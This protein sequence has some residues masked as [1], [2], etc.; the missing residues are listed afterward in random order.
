MERKL[1]NRVLDL[2]DDLKDNRTLEVMREKIYR[3]DVPNLY[4]IFSDEE[5]IEKA[6]EEY[7][8]ILVE[9]NKMLDLLEI[10]DE[11]S[12]EFYAKMNKAFSALNKADLNARKKMEEALDKKL[13]NTGKVYLNPFE[14]LKDE[15][16]I[17]DAL[18]AIEELLEATIAYRAASSEEIQRLAEVKT[19]ILK[20]ACNALEDIK[21]HLKEKIKEEEEEER[22]E[23]SNQEGFKILSPSEVQDKK[24]TPGITSGTVEREDIPVEKILFENEYIEVEY[25]QDTHDLTVFPLDTL[26]IPLIHIEGKNMAVSPCTIEYIPFVHSFR[27]YSERPSIFGRDILNVFRCGYDQMAG[28]VEIVNHISNMYDYAISLKNKNSD[29]DIL[30]E[31]KKKINRVL[32]NLRLFNVYNTDEEKNPKLPRIDGFDPYCVEL[33]KDI[34]KLDI[35][36]RIEDRGNYRLVYGKPSIITPDTY[37][38]HL[39]KYS[40]INIDTS[41]KYCRDYP[42]KENTY[43]ATDTID[44][45]SVGENDFM[46]YKRTCGNEVSISKE[47]PL[48]IYREVYG[49][50]GCSNRDLMIYT[51]LESLICDSDYYT[52][53]SLHKI[54]KQVFEIDGLTI[55]KKKKEAGNAIMFFKNECEPFLEIEKIRLEMSDGR[56][57][58]IYKGKCKNEDDPNK[59]YFYFYVNNSDE[60]CDAL[61][62]CYEGSTKQDS[63]GKQIMIRVISEYIYEV[64]YDE[65]AF[66]RSYSLT[67]TLNGLPET[68]EEYYDGEEGSFDDDVDSFEYAKEC[69]VLEE[70]KRFNGYKSVRRFEHIILLRY[71]LSAELKND[72]KVINVYVYPIENSRCFEISDSA[73]NDN[74]LNPIYFQATISKGEDGIV[75]SPLYQSFNARY[76]YYSRGLYEGDY[77]IRNKMLEELCEPFK[78]GVLHELVK[79]Y[80]DIIDNK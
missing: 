23:K 61:R 4:I 15:D 6:N 21:E 17:E 2:N 26:S 33:I 16:G 48:P 7:A 3:V 49:I 46:L 53:M 27:V 65:K 12:E 52:F 56:S 72:E 77:D 75:V 80:F 54:F 29:V 55:A 62:H 1:L 64:L 60:L 63:E 57:S 18:N 30:E 11:K 47:L 35:N 20:T 25:L 38:D 19:K 5:A 68:E 34:S 59:D 76:R 36:G 41:T 71:T 22:M 40:R 58:I 70:I 79:S 45:T 42:E 24:F 14:F 37:S 28:T 9:A 51:Y 78:S 8:K 31:I 73:K 32:V 13:K 67:R 50:P 74:Y 10:E 39:Y 69:N 44:W 66:V 43:L